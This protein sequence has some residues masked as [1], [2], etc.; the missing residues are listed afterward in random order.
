M[1]MMFAT[2]EIRRQEE[3]SDCLWDFSTMPDNGEPVQG[4]A[5]VPG[6]C[7]GKTGY[8]LHRAASFYA[9]VK[10]WNWYAG[11]EVKVCNL[12]AEHFSG[13]ISLRLNE[14]TI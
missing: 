4:K 14:G 5:V 11:V 7:A 1:L 13:K 8:A 9:P 12:G 2:H 6:Y 10:G 3:L